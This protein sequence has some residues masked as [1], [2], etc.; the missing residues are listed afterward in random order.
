MYTN[1]N[2]CTQIQTNIHKYKQNYTIQ[3]YQILTGGSESKKLRGGDE[4]KGRILY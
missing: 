1:T 2:T 4:A 3:T